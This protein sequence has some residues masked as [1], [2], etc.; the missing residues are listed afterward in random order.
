MRT[1]ALL[2]RIAGF[3]WSATRGHRLHPWSSPL[4]RWRFETYL[5]T[6]AESI[7]RAR[8]TALGREHVTELWHFLKW[9]AEMRRD[10]PA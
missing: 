8:F 3:L 9:A 5:G 6:Q 1:L 10:F 7:D 4:L 2:P